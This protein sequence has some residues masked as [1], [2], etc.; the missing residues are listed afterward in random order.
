[1]FKKIIKK[2]FKITMIQI[3]RKIMMSKVYLNYLNIC[4]LYVMNLK[5][6]YNY[7]FKM[8]KA[9]LMNIYHK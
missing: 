6:L 1:M 2:Y 9:N 8:I 7:I 3:K 5:F 4:K